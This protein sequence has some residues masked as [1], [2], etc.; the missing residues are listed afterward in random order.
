MCPK[1]WTSSVVLVVLLAS[2]PLRA[3]EGTDVTEAR[4]QTELGERYYVSGQYSDA[5][6]AFR[7][8]YL[9]KP[10]P[11]LL[12]NIAQSLRLLGQYEESQRHY[13]RC[14]REQAELL[15]APL[16][17]KARGY[18]VEMQ[19][20]QVE[21]AR[22]AAEA[23]AARR[24]RAEA[25]VPVTRRAWFWGVMAGAAV[26]VGTGV[27]LGVYYGVPPRD[28]ATDLGTYPAALR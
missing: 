11:V 15:P 26:L 25:A 24:A 12:Y 17:A 13:E 1:R 2:P 6:R 23:E 10:H 21:A 16:A 3:A 22:K 27:T 8:A 18:V 4:Q 9:R 14:L 28:P 5:L 7:Q 20:R 19:A